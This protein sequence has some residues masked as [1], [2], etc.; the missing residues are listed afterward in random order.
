M[1]IV[2]RTFG[3]RV[4]G[5]LAL[6]LIMVGRSH[7]QDADP[8]SR[9]TSPGGAPTASQPAVP[10]QNTVPCSSRPGERN[11]CDADTSAGVALVRSS[12]GAPCLLGKTWGYDDSGIW[13]SDGC[14]GEFIA[15]PAAGQTERVKPL[16]HV[17]NVGFLLY[18]GEQGEIYFR[19]FSYARYL[20]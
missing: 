2:G 18:S 17:P 15:G 4:L 16:E 13:V 12:G 20:N 3:H 10:Q 7:A 14:S 8:D 6:A 9:T 5:A 19:L 11:H 1:T